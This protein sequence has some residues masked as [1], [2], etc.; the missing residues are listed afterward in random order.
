MKYGRFIRE[1]K[2]KKAKFVDVARVLKLEEKEL[3]DKL[4]GRKPLYIHE[5]ERLFMY[6]G[7]EKGEDKIKFF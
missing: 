5:A 3:K 1:I 4:K 7:I 2:R 6:L